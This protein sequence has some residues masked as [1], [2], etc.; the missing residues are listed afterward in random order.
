[1]TSRLAFS[2][3]LATTLAIALAGGGVFWLLGLPA[4]W[5]AG[6]MLAV[7]AASLAG[8]ATRVPDWLRQAIFVL[9]GV[10]IG[11]AVSW[12]TIVHIG[13][14]P[15]SMVVMAATVG[16]VT[17]ASYVYYR[18]AA[19]W[20]PVAA[21]LGGIPGAFSM[22][23]ALAE[24]H[25]SDVPSIAVVQCI[26]LFFLIA[27]LPLV[28]TA[29][30]LHGLD[31]AADAQDMSPASLAL[32]IAAGAVAGMA[33]HRLGVP[34]GLILGAAAASS[35]LELAGLAE[36]AMPDWVL[37]P[38]F[39]VLGAMIGTRFTQF[40]LGRL[41]GLAGVG[42]ASFLLA[43]AVSAAGAFASSAL[44]G[45]EPALTLIAF[46]PG[47]LETMTIMAFALGLD[48]AFVAA[49]Q[50]GRYFLLSFAMPMAAMWAARRP[51]RHGPPPMAPQ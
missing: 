37:V 26:R 11:S 40:S 23:M 2:P 25:K 4:G 43:F 38:A 45:I 31:T 18:R 44:T 30:G 1:M 19:G 12:D 42:L 5:L 17:A 47:G 49:H 6:A 8:V 34:A 20:P 28:M 46:A 51:N 15:V 22:V 24:A 50:V 13:N 9:L 10:Q 29:A 3:A 14:W 48:P 16:A 7:T 27:V 35:G 36:G 39:V 32:V 21:L 41:K 33:A